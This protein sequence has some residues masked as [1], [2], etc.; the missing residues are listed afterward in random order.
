MHTHSIRS[1]AQPLLRALLLVSLLITAIPTTLAS[2][3][4]HAD[5]AVVHAETAEDPRATRMKRALDLVYRLYR[6]SAWNVLSHASAERRTNSLNVA[7]PDFSVEYWVTAFE[8]GSTATLTGRFP[9]WARYAA[10]TAYADDGLPFDSVSIADEG[11]GRAFTRTFTSTESDFVVLARIYRPASHPE[12]LAPA[13][14][15]AV[16]VDGKTWTVA[17][18]TRARFNGKALEWPIQYA[19]G[20]TLAKQLPSKR[21]MPMFRP[22][23]ASLPGVFPNQDARYLITYPSLEGGQCAV[24]RG[25]VPQAAPG[26]A[27]YGFMAVE[28]KTTATVASLSDEDLGGWGS[29]YTVFACRTEPN[30]RQAGYDATDPS[31][32]LLLSGDVELPGV[33]L[34]DLDTTAGQGLKA[35]DAWAE[36]GRVEPE[37]CRSVLGEAYPIMKVQ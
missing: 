7:M 35:T 8:K 13:E 1:A 16:R 2:A 26:R 25:H 24:F 23:D 29:A 28:M 21:D 31:H 19:V 17:S 27:F 32:H 6:G 5:E 10:L 34:R 15:F 37:R 9:T 12:S 18:E 3:A 11:A 36:Q 22:A 14:K 33:V 20:R 30:A 4:D